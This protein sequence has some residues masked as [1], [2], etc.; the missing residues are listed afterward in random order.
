MVKLFNDT[1]N[2]NEIIDSNSTEVLLESEFTIAD[3]MPGIEKLVDTEGKAKLNNVTVTTDNIIVDGKLIYNIIYRSNNEN[4]IIHSMSGE[5]PFREEVGVEGVTEDMEAF[6]NVFIDYID[7]EQLT[8]RSFLVK[9][10]L[11]LDT[12]IYMK[13][14][15]TYVSDLESD[16]SIQAKS[17]NIA[18]SDTIAELSEEININDAVELSKGSGEID[19]IIKTAADVYMTNMDVLNDK[20]LLE[21]ICKVGFMFVEDDEQHTIGYVSEEFPFT[22]YLE[23]EDLRENMIKD[24]SIS[25]KDMTYSTTENFDDE[26]KLIEFALPF[27]V[28]ASFYDTIEKNIIM[29]CYSTDY[30]LEL[31]SEKVNL[32][33]IKK[34]TNEVVKY[35][36]NFDLPS[37]SVKDI[38]SVDISPK[39]SEKRIADNKYIIDGFLDVNMLYLN[40]D[41]NKIDKAF[42]SLPFAAD[43][44]IDEEDALCK[45]Y[46]D[47]RVHKC[48]AYRKGNNSV[49]INCE[50]NVG[51]KFKND[52]E[53]TV[54]RDIA[55][56][57]PVDRSKMPSL[58]FRVVQSGETLWD[59]AKNYNLSINYLKELN[60]IPEDNAL[61]PGTKIIIARTV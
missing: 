12:D 35:E 59:I 26:K 33:S 19:K 10:V 38:Y 48:N 7:A 57:S 32:S 27:T 49:N 53:I 39:V 37:G 43:F 17:K 34:M 21:G 55:E 11:I 16:G 51:V 46:S 31:Q 18:F 42:A 29:D 56:R 47:I 13:R 52:E 5:I 58:I 25:V 61:E 30:E 9:A 4:G 15:V 22:H 6:T 1:F 45:I 2:I 14:P 20:M 3:D 40:G 8:E 44:L 41:I 54:I 60:D 24:I 23:L 50:I 36:N 28:N